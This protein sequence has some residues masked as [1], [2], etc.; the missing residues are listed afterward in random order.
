MKTITTIAHKRNRFQAVLILL[1]LFLPFLS[2]QGNPLFRIDILQRTLFIAGIAIRIDQFYLVLLATVLGV[3]LFLLLTLLVGRAW[4][5]WLCPQT[6]LNE[7]T[8]AAESE[9]CKILPKW[10]APAVRHF[11]SLPISLIFAAATLLWFMPWNEFLKHLYDFSNHPISTFSFLIIVL[12]LYVD[13]TLVKRSFCKSYC[14]YGR[15]QVA[16]QD[17]ATLNLLF[18]PETSHACIR[19]GS[20]VRSCPMGIDIRD[21]FQ[22]ECI[23]CGRCIDACRK[24]M[25]RRDH[26]QGLIGYRFGSNSATRFSFGTKTITLCAI[27]LLL[28]IFLITATGNRS[29]IAFAL[30]SNPTIETKILPDGTT[31]EA[32]KA[33]I[34][35]R[36]N[37][38][39][40][41]KIMAL[42]DLGVSLI[43]LGPTNDI[44]VSA[45][46]NR[47]ISF[48]IKLPRL[49][50]GKPIELRLMNNEKIV[51][52]M[53]VNR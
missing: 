17:K 18:L 5:G 10:M 2:I 32:W 36:S 31:I 20:C 9:F 19:C 43:L 39:E 6:L 11:V 1:Y 41:L 4:C 24:V 37:R 48:F 34:G 49:A 16:L 45:N 25:K 3:I 44:L 50:S 30:Q 52:K 35:N 14:P 42:S 29:D 7:V 53:K 26:P 13:S 12:L 23:S 21:G 33:I 40:R 51:G 28:T 22:I 47:T 38:A 8:E 15:F 46:E 27:A